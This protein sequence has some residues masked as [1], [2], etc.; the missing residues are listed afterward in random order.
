[1]TALSTDAGGNVQVV[2]DIIT[3]PPWTATSWSAYKAAGVNTTHKQ[4][5]SSITPIHFPGLEPTATSTHTK[6]TPTHIAPGAWATHHGVA[7]NVLTKCGID[8]KN[9]TWG[10]FCNPDFQQNLWVGY[11]YACEYED[12]HLARTE[13][14]F[15]KSLGIAIFSR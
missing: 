12:C 3:V 11:T 13:L 5:S 14:M 8:G 7:K 1:M 10:P 4:S 9:N 6:S 15:I 2:T